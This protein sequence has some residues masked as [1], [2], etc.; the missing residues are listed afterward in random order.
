MYFVE[1]SSGSPMGPR[2]CSFWVE[3]PI[4]APKPNWP[5]SVKRVEALTATVVESTSWVKR[6][7]AACEV[8]TMASVWPEVHSRMWATAASRE[9]TTAAAMSYERYSVSQSSVGGRDD[10]GLGGVRV[11]PHPL[12]GVHG[13]AGLGERV[14]GARQEGVGDV[15]V[16]EEG[17]GGVAD[18]R[19]AGPWS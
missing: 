1:V 13:D 12:V 19:G 17:L 8:V 4:S 3:M 11:G 5:P 18:A 2:A 15:L 16:D 7:A 9:S 10:G 14:Q 6:R